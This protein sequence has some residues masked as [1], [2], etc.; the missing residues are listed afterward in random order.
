[1]NREKESCVEKE[2][3]S[4]ARRS[5]RKSSSGDDWALFSAEAEYAESMVQSSLGNA[6]ASVA[7]LKRSLACKPDYAPALMSV[8][9]VEYQLG[10]RAK[11]RKLFLTL[12]SLPKNTPDIIT[13]ID[14]AGEFLIQMRNYRDGLDLYR[15]AAARFPKTAVLHQG[16]GCCAA[17]ERFFDEAIAASQR[18][19]NLEPCN[20]ELANDLG[21]SLYEAGRLEEAQ[22]LL[23]KAVAMDPANELARTNLSLCKTKMLQAKRKE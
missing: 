3:K 5:S 7:A 1:M 18:A 6:E 9:S 20:Q 21:Y 2:A 12:L 13:V 22:K 16:I 17:H 14:E 23:E 10:R 15:A 11:G 4:G 19:F 8:G